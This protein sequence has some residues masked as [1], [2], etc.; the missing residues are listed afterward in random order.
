MRRALVLVAASAALLAGAPVSS[1]SDP[2]CSGACVVDASFLQG[3]TPPVIVIPSGSNVTWH[4]TDIGHIQKETPQPLGSTSTCFTVT[5]PGH[6]NSSAVRFDIE[7]GVLNATVGATKLTC[8]NAVGV[9]GGAFAVPYHCTIHAN[10]N[11]V[12]VVTS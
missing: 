12:V 11:G 3:Y 8:R 6:G 9:E 5:A 1:S 2:V 4:A 10:M 7:D